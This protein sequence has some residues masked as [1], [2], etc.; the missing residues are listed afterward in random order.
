MTE[1]TRVPLQP[2]KKSSL[3]K[4]WIAIA[5]LVLAAAGLAWAA[6]PDVT[7]VDGGTT[8]QTVTAGEGESPTE[9]DFVR[10]AYKGTL[11]DGTVFDEN[12]DAAF[13]VNGVVPGFSKALQVMAPGGTY[14]VK[15]PAAEGYGEQGG[16]PIPPNSDLTFEVELLEFRSR[17]E[18]EA[19]QQQMMMQQQLQQQMQGQMG[20]QMQGVPSGQQ[21]PP[22]APGAAPN[23]Q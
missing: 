8:V 3:A 13:P 12:A 18:I 2:I 7:T 21:L 15:I 16:G 17:A 10:V 14:R 20:G 11:D 22:G 1:I 5:V 23:S 9:E 6:S 4:L 19:M